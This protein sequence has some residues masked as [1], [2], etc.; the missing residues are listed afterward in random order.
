M[1]RTGQCQAFERFVF[2]ASQNTPFIGRRTVWR[3]HERALV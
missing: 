1:N 3:Y 2:I